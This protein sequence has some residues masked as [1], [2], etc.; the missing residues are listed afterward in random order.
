MEEKN[1]P[2][3]SGQLHLSFLMGIYSVIHFTPVLLSST[4]NANIAVLPAD[5]SSSLLLGWMH[6]FLIYWFTWQSISKIGPS[7]SANPTLLA[8][9]DKRLVCQKCS[10]DKSHFLQSFARA[11]LLETSSHVQYNSRYSLPYS[12]LFSL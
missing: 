2:V 10:Q 1:K 4:S 11:N 7:K 6:F 3:K 12:F 8:G 5:A 9:R